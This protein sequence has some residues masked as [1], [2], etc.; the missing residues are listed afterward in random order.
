MTTLAEL[1]QLAPDPTHGQTIDQLTA[2]GG[3]EWRFALELADPLAGV[4]VEWHDL[5]GYYL[6]DIA[7]RGADEYA[8]RYRAMTVTLDLLG[9][10]NSLAPYG[11]PTPAITAADVV[12]EAGLLMR[13]VMFRTT[14]ELGAL[15]FD[16]DEWVFDDE[17]L[18]FG[19]EPTVAEWLP[20][21]TGRVESWGDATQAVGQIRTHRV[22]IVDLIG[23]LVNVPI[24][25]NVE[26][27]W[28][29][30]LGNIL[31]S[32]GWGFG[33]D[34]Y[35]K[36]DIAFIPDRDAQAS[37]INEIDATADPISIEWRTRRN[38]RLVFHPASYDVAHETDG[39]WPNS[40]YD[41]YPKGLVFSYS[42]DLY[43]VDYV[44]D[45]EVESFGITRTTQAVINSIAI[46]WP[47]PV[48]DP[49]DTAIY[50][51]DVPTSIEK[52]GRKP[53]QATWIV[54]NEPAADAL[55]DARAFATWQAL[56]M[57]TTI[58]HAGFFPA[59]ALVDHLDPV[60]IYHQPVPGGD[61]ITA[62]GSVRHINEARS[63]LRDGGL[64]WATTLQFD[65]TSVDAE[66]SLLPPENLSLGA[67]TSNSIE[68][69]WDNPAGQPST[70]TE[71]QVRMKENSLIWTDIGYP[72]SGVT[73]GGLNPGTGYTFQVRYVRRVDGII[74][75]FS[76]IATAWKVA[77]LN[78]AP[79]PGEPG[80]DDG[81]TDVEIPDLD[82]DCDLEWELQE[83]DGSGWVTILSGDR[84]DLIDNGDG[85]FRLAIDNSVF[86][87]GKVYRVRSREVCGGIPG[88]WQKGPSWDPPD[89]WD[90]P[91]PDPP[92]LLEAPF[93]DASLRVYF[94]QVCAPD[95]VGVLV[96]D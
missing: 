11:L 20:I 2:T 36:A 10:G 4:D 21:W 59:M 16:D 48:G 15:V 75:A 56:P 52:F 78:T 12:I 49:G 18:E 73:I 27:L 55:L 76:P 89:D 68:W 66:A 60:T 8:G 47:D 28:E 86:D 3:G 74:V 65:L 93:T 1:V 7:D 25:P 77:T 33:A 62:T 51:N 42:P 9:E 19:G 26:E 53:F 84:D 90:D 96:D 64:S 22:V 80:E 58:D 83:N 24:G 82:P 37:A 72:L 23:D 81:D 67:R 85:T 30:R 39:D 40:L 95:I 6:G 41:Y 13:L 29:T 38:G 46:T 5:T 94:P 57:Q 32:A 45:D 63:Y 34:Y 70:P 79:G 43:D 69:F 50:P 88:D 71:T 17:A 87:P 61:V 14:G 31:A 92:A 91:C 35:G 44:Q 54:D